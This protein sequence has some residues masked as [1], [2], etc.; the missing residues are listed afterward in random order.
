MKNLVSIVVPV[1]KVERYLDRC[2]QSLVDQTYRN[3]EII[4]VDDG[5]PDRCPKMCDDWASKDRRI[6]V[7]HKQNGGLSDA[8]NVGIAGSNGRFIAFVDSDDYVDK[9][10]IE[11][12]YMQIEK[13]GAQIACVGM[14]QFSDNV[15][16][17]LDL[18]RN[19]FV[20][21]SRED[22]IKALF[23]DT[24]FGSYAWNK[25]YDRKL[26]D[27]VK[28]PQG[29][30]MEDVAT[31]YLLFEQ[32]EL[33]SYC[34]VKVYFYYQRVDSI[35]HKVNS[36]LMTDAYSIGKT[37]YDYLKSKYPCMRENYQYFNSLILYC[38]PY[39][40]G[41]VAA[42]ARIEFKK[43]KAY[44]VNNLIGK[45]RMKAFLFE[46]SGRLYCKIWAVC[47]KRRN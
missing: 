10:F 30:L 2:V 32:C 43:N 23:D 15:P 3:V 29:K 38:Y 26:F 18:E 33:I 45:A 12:M 47:Q 40:H 34:P 27:N 17:H 11:S 8:R 20:V 36:K 39:L 44:G 13:S 14:Q 46:L 24:K 25:L 28:F 31:T 35:L 41:E 5:S 6:K 22:A 37:R 21:Y 4:L 1:Y 19:E 42:E 16:A 7:I 9:H